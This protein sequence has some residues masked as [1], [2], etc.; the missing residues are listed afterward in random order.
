M[1]KMLRLKRIIA[2]YLDCLIILIIG[3]FVGYFMDKLT[4]IN[5]SVIIISAL[6]IFKDLLFKNKSLFKKKLNLEILTVNCEK[7]SF[8]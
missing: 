8:F 2:R 1:I 4:N 7:P 3:L 6:Y 5:F